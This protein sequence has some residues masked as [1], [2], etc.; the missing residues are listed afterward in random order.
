MTFVH[1]V[2][3]RYAEIDMQRVV[4]NAHWLTYFDEANTMWWPWA[5]LDLNGTFVEGFDAMLVKAVVEWHGAAGWNDHIAIE[6]F[7]TRVGNAS[8][9]FGFRAAVGERPV[10][11][12]SLTYVSVD[13]DHRE[14]G[15]SRPLP[16]H[17]RGVLERHCRDS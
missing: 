9:D 13:T 3:P 7:P 6:V 10:C 14:G 2:R 8:F 12:A 16:D 1:H 11:S 17:I 15:R 5:G 4:F